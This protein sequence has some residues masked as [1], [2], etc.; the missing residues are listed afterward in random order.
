VIK[1]GDVKRA[2]LPVVSIVL[3]AIFLVG[4]SV[5]LVLQWPPGPANLDWGVWILAYFG[6]AYIIAA[7]IYYVKTDK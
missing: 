7:A 1:E 6:Y 2:K 5:M 4:G 3:M